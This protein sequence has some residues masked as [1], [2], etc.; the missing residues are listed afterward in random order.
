MGLFTLISL[1]VWNHILHIY[2]RIHTEKES[3]SVCQEFPVY[4][5][6]DCD[7]DHHDHDDYDHEEEEKEES[8]AE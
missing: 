3:V 5:N 4:K 6:S 1:L 2:T 8:K 7:D